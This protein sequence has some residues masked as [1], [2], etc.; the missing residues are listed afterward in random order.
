MNELIKS[1]FKTVKTIEK[2]N[3]QILLLH[4]RVKMQGSKCFYEAEIL[5]E[6]L[7]C[8][9]KYLDADKKEL[10]KTNKEEGNGLK[11]DQVTHKNLDGIIRILIFETILIQ[12]D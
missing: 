11:T 2:K 12:R 9:L 1:I 3:S 5:E 7:T 6:S 4:E 8:E 10:T